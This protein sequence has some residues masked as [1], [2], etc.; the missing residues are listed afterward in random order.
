MLLISRML[1]FSLFSLSLNSRSDGLLLGILVAITAL[2]Q[3]SSTKVAR[4]SGS[5][6]TDQKEFFGFVR[7]GPRYRLAYL[8]GWFFSTRIHEMK[9]TV[10]VFGFE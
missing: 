7:S 9:R 3:H 6:E 8:S 4:T 2:L 10:V 1:L 5:L